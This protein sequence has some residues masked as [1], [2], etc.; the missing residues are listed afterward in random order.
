MGAIGC[1]VALTVSHI[2]APIRRLGCKL[3]LRFV[4]TCPLYCAMCLGFWVGLVF[5]SAHF[6]D[7]PSSSPFDYLC[8]AFAASVLSHCCVWWL[9]KMGHYCDPV[10]D[11]WQYGKHGYEEID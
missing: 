4:S 2:C 5:S 9:R 10:H 3:L 8:F 6:L 1:T 7:Q 11:G